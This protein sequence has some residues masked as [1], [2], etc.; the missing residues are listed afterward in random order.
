[1][2][3]NTAPEEHRD[4]ARRALDGWY[5]PRFL[6]FFVALSLLRFDGEFTFPPTCQ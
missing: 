4:A 1:M 5:A 3:P 2:P 6:A